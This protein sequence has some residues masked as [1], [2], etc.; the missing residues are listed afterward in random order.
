MLY[1]IVFYRAWSLGLEYTKDPNL[2][3]MMA[4]DALHTTVLDNS[5]FV[6]TRDVTIYNSQRGASNG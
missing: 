1:S 6:I 5:W 2:T 3:I 4:V